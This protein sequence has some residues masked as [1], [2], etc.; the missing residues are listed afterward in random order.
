MC[1]GDPFLGPSCRLWG[2]GEGGEE[3]S[4]S[5]LVSQGTPEEEHVGK[6]TSLIESQHHHLLHCLEKTTVSPSPPR[7]RPPPWPF[8]RVRTHIPK[9]AQLP[10][11]KSVPFRVKSSDGVSLNPR[12][13]APK[14]WGSHRGRA[15]S[16]LQPHRGLT[17]PLPTL[18]PSHGRFSVTEAKGSACQ[19][20]GSDGRR[21]QSQG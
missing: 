10:E 17:R 1:H 7:P 21:L 18:P 16:A 5:I 6:T 19:S 20:P 15:S 9:L 14:K 3:G 2:S 11:S 12:E 8:P 4:S 13:E